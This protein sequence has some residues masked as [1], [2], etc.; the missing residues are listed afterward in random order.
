L[1]VGKREGGDRVAFD[2]GPMILPFPKV[3]RVC[4]KT[5]IRALKERVRF[6][7]WCGVPHW[8]TAWPLDPHHIKSRGAGGGDTLDNLVML[9]RPCHDDAQTYKIH[10]AALLAITGPRVQDP[11]WRQIEASTACMGGEKP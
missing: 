7:E 6:C 8:K 1:I 5:L 11:V 9:C 2:G 4:N 3:K 10:K